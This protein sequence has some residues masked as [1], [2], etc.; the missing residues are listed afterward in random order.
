MGP[1]F[2]FDSGIL[3][4]GTPSKHPPTHLPDKANYGVLPFQLKKNLVATGTYIL[5][6]VAYIYRSIPGRVK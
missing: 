5:T 6:L 3:G 4:L 1:N 2:S